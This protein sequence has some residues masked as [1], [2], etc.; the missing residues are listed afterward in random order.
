[1]PYF[2]IVCIQSDSTLKNNELIW[3]PVKNEVVTKNTTF[4]LDQDRDLVQG[5]QNVTPI[6]WK[7]CVAYVIQTEEPMSIFDGLIDEMIQ[8]LIIFTYADGK[9]RVD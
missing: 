5:I 4:K 6:N 9:C 2:S 1:M 3:A 7:K 8:P